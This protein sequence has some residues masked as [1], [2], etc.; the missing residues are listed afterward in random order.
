M[1]T[2]GYIVL[3]YKFCK[4][5][6]RWVAH[7]MELGTSTFGRS[8]QQAEKRIDDAVLCHLNCLEEVGERERFFKEHHIRFYQTKP[9]ATTRIEAQTSTDAF[10]QHRIQPVPVGATC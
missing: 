6:N 5:G 3:T 1:A 4:E 7:C 9:K 10:Y 8:L 2:S